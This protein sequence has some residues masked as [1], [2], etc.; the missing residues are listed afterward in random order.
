MV[1]LYLKKKLPS[2]FP[3]MVLPFCIPTSNVGEI[4]F[5][6][7]PGFGI[8]SVL[9]LFHSNMGVVVSPHGF[10]LH[11]PNAYPYNFFSEVIVQVLCPFFPLN[12]LLSEF[13][14]F[15]SFSFEF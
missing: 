6:L 13:F 4:P 15:F 10:S 5:F 7:L 11:F 14:S 1:E 3:R 8:S 2:C 12:H 9:C